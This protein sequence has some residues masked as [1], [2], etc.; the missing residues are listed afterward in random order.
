MLGLLD[1]LAEKPFP[2]KG[3]GGWLGMLEMYGLTGP[4]QNR[5]WT[6]LI[7][8][9]RSGCAEAGPGLRHRCRVGR[10]RSGFRCSF[11]RLG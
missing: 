9:Y 11:H 4:K 7:G 8:C 10:R 3:L 5:L 6:G 1:P 2:R